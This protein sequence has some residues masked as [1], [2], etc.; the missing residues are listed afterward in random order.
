VVS[1]KSDFNAGLFVTAC[2]AY[3]AADVLNPR[4]FLNHLAKKLRS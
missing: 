3:D 1:G 2:A 4:I